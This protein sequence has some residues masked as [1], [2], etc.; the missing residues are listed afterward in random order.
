MSLYL[1]NLFTL[2]GEN[3][4]KTLLV[5]I[6]SLCMLTIGCDGVTEPKPKA[7]TKQILPLSVGNWWQYSNLISSNSQAYMEW[8]VSGT[9]KFS[10]KE[11]YVVTKS[12]YNSAIGNQFDTSYYRYESEDLVSYS[13]ETG[14]E[15]IEF[16]APFKKIE[17]YESII[18]LTGRFLIQDSMDVESNGLVFENCM[19][20]INNVANTTEPGHD[21]MKYGVGFVSMSGFKW[22]YSLKAYHVN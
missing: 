3:P 11:D 4:M 21:I 1:I 2:K 7:E 22:Y 20:F 9:A 18:P 10:N 6:A 19:E 17:S 12:S 15:T 13:P 16:D 14:N 8:K 5:A